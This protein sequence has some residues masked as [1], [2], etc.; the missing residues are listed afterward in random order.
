VRLFALMSISVCLAVTLAFAAPAADSRDLS[1]HT[2]KGRPGHADLRRHHS[3][4][5]G[6]RRRHRPQKRHR[7]GISSGSPT[8]DPA[9]S[10]GEI[11]SSGIAVSKPQAAEGGSPRLVW[12]DEFNGPEGAAPDPSKWTFDVGGNGWGNNELQ[13]YTARRSNASLDGQGD[14][15]ITARAERYRGADGVERNYTSARLQTL[16]KVEFTYGLMEAHIQVP[17]GT[18]LAPAFWT[19]GNDAYKGEEGWPGCGEI[20]A[21]EVLGSEPNV[22]NGTLH[23][24]WPSAPNGIGGEVESTAP[25]SA[26]F[27]TYGVRWEPDQISFLLDGSVYK[28]VERTD[29]PPGSAWPFQHPNFLLLNL[30]VGGE[31]PGSPNASTQF[32]ARMVVDWVR[33]WQ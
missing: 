8:S 24:P 2:R 19:L 5:P 25:L 1:A 23:G 32:P 33:V 17:A 14:L 29:L 6:S 7:S 22:L 4:H 27:H 13:Y 21:M 15:V 30:A 3:H 20:D 26:G 16:E 18:G 12:A 9:S 10:A 11:L 28:T 31:W